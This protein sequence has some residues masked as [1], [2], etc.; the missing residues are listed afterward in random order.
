MVEHS[1]IIE[2]ERYITAKEIANTLGMSISTATKLLRSGRIRSVNVSAGRIAR[3]RVPVSAFREWVLGQAKE[4]AAAA[5]P[6]SK[7]WPA[8][9]KR[10]V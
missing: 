3:Y 9:V 7:A 5:P 10:I 8:N 4:T 2:K 6:P 1:G